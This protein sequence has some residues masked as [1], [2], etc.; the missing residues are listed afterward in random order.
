M[1]NVSD[2]RCTGN[3]NINF[4]YNTFFFENGALMNESG[5]YCRTGQAT[6]ANMAHALFMLDT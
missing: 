2:K 3:Q 5:K 4:G 6:D 1:R